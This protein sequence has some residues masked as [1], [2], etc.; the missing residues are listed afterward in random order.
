MEAYLTTIQG[1]IWIEIHTNTRN[2]TYM[3][4]HT[5]SCIDIY[6]CLRMCVISSL[7]SYRYIHCSDFIMST[8]AFQITG[9]S[10]VCPTV[11]SGANQRKHQISASLA[12]CEGNPPVTDGFPHKGQVTR[13]MFPFDDVIV[14][15]H[16]G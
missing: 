5:Y 10:I 4:I 6:V 3:Y 12:I 9:V 8:M 14:T 2:H 11:C 15:P 7:R 1:F 16:P 13:K